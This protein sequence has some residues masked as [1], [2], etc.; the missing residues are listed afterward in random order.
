MSGAMI[1]GRT[2]RSSGRKIEN[3]NFGK[4]KIRI[5]KVFHA[6]QEVLASAS[7]S[8]NK[9]VFQQVMRFCK[10]TDP[11]ARFPVLLTYGCPRTEHYEG[12]KSMIF[13]YSQ[14]FL[15]TPLDTLVSTDTYHASQEVLASASFSRNK[16]VFQQVMRF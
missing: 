8:R 2:D 13:K 15:A 5:S 16:P 11:I 10:V 6:S 4:S 1:V 14:H 12:R 9:P 3:L 7:F